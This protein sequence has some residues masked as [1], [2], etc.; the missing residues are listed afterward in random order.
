M[1]YRELQEKQQKRFNAL[2]IVFAFGDKQFQEAKN[3]LGEQ[4]NSKLFTFGGGSLMRKEDKH[5]LIKHYELSEK[6]DAE[7]MQDDAYVYQMFYYELG[8]HEYCYTMDLT[9]TLNACGFDSE[10]DLRKNDRIFQICRKA[11]NKYLEE[12]EA[13]DWY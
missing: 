7:A 2:P 8:N 9:D 6:E 13:N 12:C 5:L 3:K 1:D 10:E 11:R 4:D